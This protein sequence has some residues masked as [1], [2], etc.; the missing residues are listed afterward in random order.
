MPALWLLLP[1]LLTMLCSPFAIRFCQQHGLLAE[2][3][4]RRLHKNP[5]PHGGGLLLPLIGVPAMLLATH[6]GALG[7][8]VE[9]FKLFISVMLV[10]SLAVAFVGWWDDKHNIAPAIRLTVHLLAVGAGLACLPPL[11]D[12]M[13]LILE[14]L[15]LLLAWGWFVNLYNFMDGADGLA[16]S[17]GV[18]IGLGIALIVP[19]IAPLAGVIMGICLGFLRVNWSPARVFLG[20]VG[21]TW[22]GYTLGGL[23]FVALI[24]DTWSVIWPLSTIT[25]VFCLDATST[26][27]RRMAEGHKPWVPHNTFWFQRFLALGYKHSTLALAV[28]GLNALLLAVALVAYTAQ[29]SAFALPVGILLVAS[30]AVWIRRKEKQK[31]NKS[32]QPTLFNL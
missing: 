21:S 32:G 26:L 22:L 27:I 3:D 17:E 15:I 28:T 2:D 23:L 18:A 7:T 20:D 5:T 13:P 24:N 19:S 6:S 30:T 16:T 10:A 29:A 12:F 8:G 11:F 4:G 9:S 25:L 1:F 14:K 31:R